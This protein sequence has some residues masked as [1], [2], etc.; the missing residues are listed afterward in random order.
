MVGL[1]QA[2]TIS[3]DSLHHLVDGSILGDDGMLQFLSHTL[4]SDTLLFGHPLGR[5]T[6][7]H[8]DD[9]CHLFSIYHL[10]LLIFALAPALVELLQFGLQHGLTVTVARCQFEVLILD[11]PL[12]L[13]LDVGDLFLLLHDLR[14]YLGIAKMHARARLVE[15]VDRLIGHETV[16]HIAVCQFDTCHQRLVGIG[17]VMVLFVTVL[18]V[19]QDLQCLLVGGRLYLYLLESALQ[20]SVLLYRVTV[21]VEC[22]GTD[23]LDGA[24]C[25]R[26]FHD[27]GGIH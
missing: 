6:R 20:G 5:N 9:F 13:L 27:V 1:L 2:D 23:A 16:C 25:Q 18:D 10:S 21:F 17:D 11:S 4:Q 15:G 3:L 14:R 7:H 22:R 12:F 24:A 8:R 26:G 19:P